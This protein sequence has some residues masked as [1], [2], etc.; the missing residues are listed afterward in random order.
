M[1]GNL[2]LEAKIYQRS[3]DFS[4]GSDKD[5]PQEKPIRPRV[6][7]DADRAR[8]L[9]DAEWGMVLSIIAESTP[10][11]HVRASLVASVASGRYDLPRPSLSWVKDLVKRKLNAVKLWAKNRSEEAIDT[12]TRHSTYA[13]VT[14]TSRQ[15]AVAAR[16]C[17]ADGRGVGRWKNLSGMPIPPL[18]DAAPFDI[19]ACRNCCRPV[20]VSIPDRQKTARKYM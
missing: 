8:T 10:D 3:T 13:V 17:L 12:L 14:F 9:S 6:E 19:I 18:A 16:N 5:S 20:T 7:S 1:G 11:D 15:A 4:P 2:R